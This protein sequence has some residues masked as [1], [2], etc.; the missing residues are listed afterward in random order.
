MVVVFGSGDAKAQDFGEVAPATCPQC[1]NEV[2]M[3]KIRSEKQFSLYFIPLGSY[4]K[5]EYLVCPICHFALQIQAAHNTAVERMRA[6]TASFRRGGAN[7]SFYETALPASGRASGATRLGARSCGR[8]GQGRWARRHQ[9]DP[10]LKR[11][12][13]PRPRT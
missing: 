12:S 8:R 13:G 1:H 6:A 11:N 2:F 10:C 4:R 9:P 5:D 3:H 7:V